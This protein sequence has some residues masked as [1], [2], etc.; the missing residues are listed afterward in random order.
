MPDTVPCPQPS[1]VSSPATF[2][3]REFPALALAF[4]LSAL[5]R[6]I[7]AVLAPRIAADEGLGE[8]EMGFL[9]GAYL[10]GFALAQLPVGALLA[11][12]EPR[13]L[14]ALL[15]GIAAGG[16]GLWSLGQGLPLLWTGRLLMG[17]GLSGCLIAALQRFSQTLAGPAQGMATSALMAAGGVGALCATLPT[18]WLAQKVGWRPLFFVCGLACLGVAGWLWRL[19]RAQ[20]SAAHLAHYPGNAVARARAT[21]HPILGEPAFRRFAAQGAVIMG[22]FAALEGLWMARWLQQLGA[23]SADQLAGVL[24]LASCASALGYL[25]LALALRRSARGQTGPRAS[26]GLVCQGYGLHLLIL[27]LL[28]LVQGWPNPLNLGPEASLGA[29]CLWPL[30][31]AAFAVSNLAYPLHGQH[32]LPAHRGL[33]HGA[34]NLTIFLGAFAWQWGM[35]GI[36]AVATALGPGPETGFRLAFGS[37]LLIQTLS[38]AYLWRGV[39]QG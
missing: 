11:N 27:L 24:T 37:L 17:I 14:E 29:S 31:C 30:A 1:P 36:V 35:G 7:N 18:H 10:L 38:L 32:Y 28:Y 5:L 39:R 21:L 9:T 13:R 3:Q 34:L 23:L 33:A 19:A 16:C 12:R 26:L 25:A 2:W 8:P 22:G 20:P 4:G 15:L 6:N